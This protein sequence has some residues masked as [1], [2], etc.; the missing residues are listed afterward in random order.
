ML[1]LEKM[2]IYIPTN[3]R[4]FFA[5]CL[6]SSGTFKHCGKC[7]IARY[8]SPEC[9]RA[10]HPN[11]VIINVQDWAEVHKN[12]CCKTESFIKVGSSVAIRPTEALLSSYQTMYAKCKSPYNELHGVVISLT[13]I[14]I[15]LFDSNLIAT[16][17]FLKEISNDDIIVTQ[18]N[19]EAERSFET[20]K[21]QRLAELVEA[22][23]KK[24]RKE[25][26]KKEDEEEKKRKRAEKMAL[27]RSL[28]LEKKKEAVI[29]N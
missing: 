22:E 10:V 13:P 20:Q 1:A 25:I 15:E 18:W 16:G 5:N 29:P 28:L 14:K 21:K 11:V 6:Q 26:E 19:L 24:I 23:K 17:E 4:C 3:E 9:Q 2:K 7:R 27:L 12:A 8:C